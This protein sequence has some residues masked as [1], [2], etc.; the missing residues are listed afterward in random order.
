MQIYQSVIASNLFSCVATS[1]AAE[2]S[3]SGMSFI[4]SKLRNRLRKKSV[5]KLHYI[6]NNR[7]ALGG[8]KRILDLIDDED[9]E[10][11]VDE[12]NF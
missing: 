2:R 7:I 4:Q 9:V 5:E 10:E 1:A 3:F 12:F 11:E 6:R 8:K